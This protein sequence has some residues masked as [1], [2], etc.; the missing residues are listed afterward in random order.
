MLLEAAASGLSFES[1]PGNTA[2]I[3][4]ILDLARQVAASDAPV[5]ILDVGAGG[6]YHAFNVWQPFV[7]YRES[8][9]L[10][11][12]DVAHLEVTA[13]RAAELEFSVDLRLGGVE[14]IVEEFGESAFD[15]V[16]STQVLEHLRD[17]RGGVTAMARVLRPG[18]TLYVT[19]DSGDLQRPA[20]QKARLGAK[21]V[22]ARATEVAPSLKR[23]TPL[24]G[25]WER[26][27][28]LDELRRQA[29]RC[30]LETEVIRH[31]GLGELKAAAAA[32]DTRS[33]LLVLGLEEQ[34]DATDPGGFRLLYL[35]ALR[36][37]Q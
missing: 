25:D 13:A 26:A 37:Q 34:L 29:D 35:R 18:G 10:Y 7:P 33:R 11:G 36:P 31:F 16:V 23:F 17:W 5:R 20:T 21:C 2:K 27:P 32:L 1:L 8:I 9:D 3:R 6:R 19:C 24:S 12:V 15:A 28:T 4:L 30:G 14:S 22:Y